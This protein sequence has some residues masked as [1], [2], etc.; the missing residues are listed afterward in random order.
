VWHGREETAVAI[1]V[2]GGGAECR[3]GGA[4]YQG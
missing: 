3:A 1:E 4:H 2:T